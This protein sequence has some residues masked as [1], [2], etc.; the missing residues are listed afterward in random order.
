MERIIRKLDVCGAVPPHKHPI[1]GLFP[2]PGK[3]A[4]GLGLFCYNQPRSS[5]ALT[6][7]AI[8]TM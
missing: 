1:S 2:L 6:T 8:A 4:R 3:G 5:I 7:R